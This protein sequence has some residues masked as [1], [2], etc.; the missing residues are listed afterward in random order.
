V[1]ESA[2]TAEIVRCLFGLVKL[3]FARDSRNSCIQGEQPGFATCHQ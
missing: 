2:L 1:R 3:A